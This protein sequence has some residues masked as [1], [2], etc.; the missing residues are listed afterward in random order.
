MP[1]P[2]RFIFVENVPGF[3]DSVARQELIDAITSRGGHILLEQILCPQQTL[4]IP[5]ARPRYYLL[6]ELMQSS[7]SNAKTT[8][9]FEPVESRLLQEY[10]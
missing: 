5:N 10:L 2:P 9:T 8:L 7:P 4:G 3:A 1:T 6:A